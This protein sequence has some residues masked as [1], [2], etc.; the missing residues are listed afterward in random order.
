MHKNLFL[1]RQQPLSCNMFWWCILAMASTSLRNS[2]TFFCNGVGH[3]GVIATSS[4]FSS[5]PYKYLKTSKFKIHWGLQGMCQIVHSL[6]NMFNTINIK[7][8]HMNLIRIRYKYLV[9]YY[10]KSLAQNQFWMKVFGGCLQC[11]ECIKLQNPLLKLQFYS[12]LQ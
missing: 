4:P 10:I 6:N 3:I 2:S 5:T 1:N 11:I 9:H 12:L 8:G 7:F